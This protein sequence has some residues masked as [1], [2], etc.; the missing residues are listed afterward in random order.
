MKPMILIPFMLLAMQAAA[1][2][3]VASKAGNM[4]TALDDLSLALA[5][6]GYHLVKVQPLDH[7]LVKR[8]FEDPG[9]RLVFIGKEAQVQQALAADPA[10]LALLPMRLT[11]VQ[12]EDQVI[13]S[14]D[15]LAPWQSRL[16]AESGTL[17]A[18]QDD[19]SEML[20]DFARQ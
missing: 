5:N 9:V 1:S 3:V 18:W 19:L 11:M 7:A 13:V 4:Q 17:R 16:P 20:K 12:K 6:H 14:S 10:L 2:P 8:G 15:D